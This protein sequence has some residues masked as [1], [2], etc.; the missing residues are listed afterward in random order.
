MKQYSININENEY[1]TRAKLFRSFMNSSSYTLDFSR[2]SNVT[3]FVDYIFLLFIRKSRAY[4]F[5]HTDT[6]ERTKK[7]D[8][9]LHNS[10]GYKTIYTSR[11]LCIIV[12]SQSVIPSSELNSTPYCFILFY[13]FHFCFRP[14]TNHPSASI[15]NHQILPFVFF[16]IYTNDD[17]NGRWR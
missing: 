2:V 5:Q 14:N 3:S 1:P 17:S 16:F 13:T 9:I 8:K 6:K 11:V 4:I 12:Y 15:Y 10:K 7:I